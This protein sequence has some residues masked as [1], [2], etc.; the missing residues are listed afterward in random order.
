MSAIV[1]KHIQRHIDGELGIPE[2]LH[3][4]ID[5]GGSILDL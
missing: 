2:A 3:F 4:K 1:P 5:S